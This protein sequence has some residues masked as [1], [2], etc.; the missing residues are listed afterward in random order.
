M[1]ISRYRSAIRSAIR[2][3]WTGVFD[4]SQFD[5]DMRI[6]IRQNLTLAW[7]AGARECGIAPDDMSPD[8]KLK[9]AEYIFVQYSFI[10]GV[11][12]FI[13][14]NSKKNK[15]KL[16]TVF[17]R[18]ELWINRY[19]EVKNAA[20]TMACADEKLIWQYGRTKDHCSTCASMVGKVK[21]ASQWLAHGIL[22]QSGRLA[23]GGWR[24][25]C[26]LYKTDLPLS[27]GRLP[28]K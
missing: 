28:S 23:C 25:K 20:K 26:G 16:G 5:A 13:E 10:G 9:L 17:K 11:G 7:H 6:V 27:K 2:G 1:S 12:D 24:C 3:L 18:G 14:R 8:E 22:P 4:Q 21:R 15:G 19:N